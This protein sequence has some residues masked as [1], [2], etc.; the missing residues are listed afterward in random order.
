MRRE[1]ALTLLARCVDEHREQADEVQS[2]RRA[3]DLA[4]SREPRRFAFAIYF[5]VARGSAA[6]Y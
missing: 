4:L 6:S 5:C 1:S 2:A 3:N